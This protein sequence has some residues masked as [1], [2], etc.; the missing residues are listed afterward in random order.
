MSSAILFGLLP[1]ASYAFVMGIT[2]GPNNL[3]LASSGLRFGFGKTIPHWL[4]IHGGFITLLVLCS[5]GIGALIAQIPMLAMGLKVFGTIYLLSLAWVMRSNVFEVDDID[6]GKPM[7]FIAAALFQFVNPKAWVM[8]ISASAAFIP[9]LEPYWLAV[10]LF[11]ATF[12]IIGM[13]CGAV[14]LLTGVSLK[15]FLNSPKWRSISAWIML[16]LI[17]VSAMG[18][19]I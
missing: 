14:W 6:A 7:G 12:T 13:P 8:A 4:G 2:P 9:N 5:I 15:R 1:L 11:V 19:W 16:L 18:I 3:L 17:L 10:T